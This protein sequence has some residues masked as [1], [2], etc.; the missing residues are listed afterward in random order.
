MPGKSTTDKFFTLKRM[1][2]QIGDGDDLFRAMNQ[3]CTP[4]KIQEDPHKA[5][6]RSGQYGR[7]DESG[8]TRK[9]C[10][11]REVGICGSFISSKVKK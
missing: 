4:S 6:E 8:P 3:F 9:A 2:L 5:T 7:I 10:F 1:I 11:S